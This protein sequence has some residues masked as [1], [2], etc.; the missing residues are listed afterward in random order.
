MRPKKENLQIA[1]ETLD[2]LRAVRRKLRTLGLP[3]GVASVQERVGRIDVD[4]GRQADQ[5]A[6]LA[7]EIRRYDHG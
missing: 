4:L 5:L 7:N 1:D 3:S 2:D 6:I